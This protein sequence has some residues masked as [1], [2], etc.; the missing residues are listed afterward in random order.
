LWEEAFNISWWAMPDMLADF[1]TII[2]IGA[3]A[4]FLARRLS[5]P[6]VKFVTSKSDYIILAIVVAPFITG[7]WAYHQWAG[8]KLFLLLHILSGEI[9]LMAIPFTRLSHM[10]FSP[11][12]RAYTGS[13][14]GAIRH[15]IDW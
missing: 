11:L 12:T 1:M 2:V 9:M 6:E 15:A 8:Y 10:I 14:F 5:S 3:C 13:E 4:F 7:F